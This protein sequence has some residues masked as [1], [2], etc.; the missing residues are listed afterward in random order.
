MTCS[1]KT[2]WT[3]FCLY[4]HI[5]FERFIFA[6]P[7][8]GGW[9]GGAGDQDQDSLLVKRRNDNHSPGCTGIKGAG[10]EGAVGGGRV[11]V[12]GAGVKG[13]GII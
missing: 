8:K 3:D 12:E 4:L 6:F 13:A 7:F 1:E 2:W 5:V 9:A 11:G 10:I